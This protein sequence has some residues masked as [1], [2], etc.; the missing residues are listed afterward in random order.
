VSH[1]HSHA[2]A[3]FTTALRL[4]VGLNAGFVLVELVLGFAAHSLALLADA[5]H[6][7][8]DVLGLLLAWG[9]AEMAR[10]RPTTRRTYGL[11]RSTILAALANALLLLVAI[12]AIGLEAIQRLMSPHPVSGGIVAIVAGAG[13]LVNGA[14]AALFFSGRREDLNIRGA[15]LHMAA[16]AA[17]S[18]AVLLAGLAMMATGRTWLDPVASLIVATVILWGTW[19]LLRESFALAMDAV[20]VGIDPERVRA[21]L[22]GLPGVTA[23]HDLHIW[24]MST[25]EAALTAHLVC[26]DG[27]TDEALVRARDDLHARFGIEHTTLQIE[28]GDAGPC[29][30]E[31]EQVV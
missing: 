11:R 28:H 17:V 31:S 19:G 1:G 8:S 22:A 30:Q 14:T 18:A 15:F 4:G 25:T 21:H 26:P 6:N 7:L 9:A 3:R 24:G 16:D 29:A 10:R 23:V 2:P 13:V 27:W 12:G 5:G 20:P